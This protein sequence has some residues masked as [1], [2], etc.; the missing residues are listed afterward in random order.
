M[1]FW[2]VASHKVSIAWT[3][4]LSPDHSDEPMVRYV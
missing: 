2:E 1:P 3:E 4:H